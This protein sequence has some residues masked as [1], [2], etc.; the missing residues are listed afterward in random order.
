LASAF[1]S[2]EL[3]S[4]PMNQASILKIALPLAS[5]LLS[6]ATAAGASHRAGG[7][8]GGGTVSTRG[9]EGGAGG[10]WWRWCHK[11]VSQDQVPGLPF[12]GSYKM[13]ATTIKQNKETG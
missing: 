13:I 11:N 1:K 3:A 7:A 4:P 8:G 5:T 9:A 6:H 10:S 12:R 2:L